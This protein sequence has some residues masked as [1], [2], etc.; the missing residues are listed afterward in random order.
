MGR[1]KAFL[2][3]EG[4]PLI[5]HVLRTLRGIFPR[6]IIVTKDPAAY[7]SYGMVVVNDALDKPGPLTGIYSGLLHST[8]D[9]NFVVACGGG[10]VLDKSNIGLMRSS[11]KIVCLS[12]F[13]PPFLLFQI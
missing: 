4:I 13:A 11:G 3:F 12:F 2:T 6:T 8:D 1:E 7:A 10:I 5:E 9:H